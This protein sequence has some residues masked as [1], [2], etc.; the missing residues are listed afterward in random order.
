MASGSSSAGGGVTRLRA[1]GIEKR[2]PGVRALAG[3]DLD[4]AAGEV[5]A[6][7]GENGAGKSTLMNVL[8]GVVPP[9]AGSI[10]VEGRRCSFARVSDAQAVGVALIHQ[11]L[12]LCERL[13]VAAN[14]RLGRE[15]RRR[16]LLDR[17]RDD[18]RARRALARIGLELAPRTPVGELAIGQRQMVEIAKALDAE[19]RILIM[20]EPTS[21]L[22]LA[23]SERL[24]GLV[25]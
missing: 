8:A 12:C 20:D 14:V 19:A 11:E 15:S 4:V 6:V 7:V 5:L 2:F 13:D 10:E 1:R 18:A 9:D 17:S 16:G 21:S 23:E 25:T 3:V 24:F 22:S